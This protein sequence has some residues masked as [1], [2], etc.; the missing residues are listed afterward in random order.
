VLFLHGGPGGGCSVDIGASSTRDVSH[1]A[2]RTSA[3]RQLDAAR[4]G[5]RQH[6]PPP[7]ARH[8]TLRDY[9]GV[10]KWLVLRRFLG[11]HAALAYGQAQPSAARLRAARRIP[12]PAGRDPVVS[13]WTA[14]GIF[15]RHWR[16]FAGML[17]APSAT[18]CSAAISSGCSTTMT[19]PRAV[20]SRLEASTRQLLDAAAEAGNEPGSNTDESIGLGAARG[21]LLR[22]R[23]CFLCR[24]QLL[25]RP[26]HRIGTC[27]VDRAAAVNDMICPNRQCDETG[28]VPGDAR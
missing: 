14:P 24:E 18:T 7:G 23:K 15:P 4:R 22:A 16:R 1:V 8:E 27:G 2:V 21:A 13:L 6:Q 11:Q 9:L 5:A 20:R 26:T 10:K 19:G 12:R 28:P 17:P 3:A 25:T